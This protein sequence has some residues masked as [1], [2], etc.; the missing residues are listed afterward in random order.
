VL[1]FE[2]A[3]E[4]TVEFIGTFPYA[5]RIYDET[6]GVRK[7]SMSKYP[8]TLYLRIDDT[9][10]EVIAFTFLHQK[11]DPESMH[12]LVAERLQDEL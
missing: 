9:V 7:F 2:G 8:Y 5:T 1:R 12:K 10:M 3:L 4:A 6:Y 11:R